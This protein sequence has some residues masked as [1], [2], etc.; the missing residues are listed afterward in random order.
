MH[1]VKMIENENEDKI[2]LQIKS[3]LSAQLSIPVEKMH[4]NDSLFHDFGIDGDDALELIQE[5]SS[6]FN[7]STDKFNLN[8]YFGKELSF[9]PIQAIIELFTKQNFNN[10]PRLT[11]QDLIIGVKTGELKSN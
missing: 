11:V 5:Y 4:L 1:K 2:I 10:T 3:F 7:V 8:E 6:R 9:S